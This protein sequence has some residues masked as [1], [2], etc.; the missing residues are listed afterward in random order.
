MSG[1]GARRAGGHRRDACPAIEQR[2]RPA[3][4]APRVRFGIGA[5]GVLAGRIGQVAGSSRPVAAG[6]DRRGGGG[7]ALDHPDLLLAGLQQLD[8]GR[9]AG[10]AEA[11]VVLLHDAGVAARPVG[12]PRADLAEELLQTV[13][14]E[15]FFEPLAGSICCLSSCRRC[16]CRGSGR[17]ASSPGGGSAAPSACGLLL[18]GLV[19][20]GGG[21]D[22]PRWPSWQA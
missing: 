11:A 10:V 2:E 22:R 16:R 9:C 17:A 8:D 13:S 19:L 20:A 5:P 3:R 15:I 21:G 6:R 12:V 1:Y 18:L 7:L 14:F 4:I